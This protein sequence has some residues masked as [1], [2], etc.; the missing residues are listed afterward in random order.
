MVS[1]IGL[2]F[3]LQNDHGVR[4]PILLLPENRLSVTKSTPCLLN[5]GRWRTL[6]WFVG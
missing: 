4:C 2:L 6:S 5:L 3:I 1:L